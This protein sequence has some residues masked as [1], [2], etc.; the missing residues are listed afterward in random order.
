M[1]LQCIVSLLI[2]LLDLVY[3]FNASK[4]NMLNEMTYIIHLCIG[5][6]GGQLIYC[7]TGSLIQ[8]EL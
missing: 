8:A 3:I 4:M 2:R 7:Y 6:G 1:T 5:D